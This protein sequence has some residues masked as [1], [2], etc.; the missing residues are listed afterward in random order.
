MD[1]PSR[2]PHLNLSSK[3]GQ[4]YSEADCHRNTKDK[5]LES[6]LHI[7]FK[8]YSLIF[9]ANKPVCNQNNVHNINWQVTQ[10]SHKVTSGTQFRNYFLWDNSRESY[11]FKQGYNLLGSQWS[12][13][14]HLFFTFQ[15][16]N[17]QAIIE[18]SSLILSR[19]NYRSF[20]LP[21]FKKIFCI[22]L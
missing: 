17:D 7:W 10:Q 22:N 11:I 1:D 15:M 2:K 13:D 14:C 9:F 16:V 20:L 4:P 12:Q 6:L 5:L 3:W 19:I 21:S 18:T 8:K